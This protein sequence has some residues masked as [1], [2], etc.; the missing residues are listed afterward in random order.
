MHPRQWGVRRRSSTDSA[1]KHKAGDLRPDSIMRTSS[2]SS[3]SD[4]RSSHSSSDYYSA[5]HHSV[6]SRTSSDSQLCHPAPIAHALDSPVPIV[7]RNSAG[8]IQAGTLHGIVGELIAQASQ[9]VYTPSDQ[10][11]TDEFRRPLTIC[12]PTTRPVY[13]DLPHLYR[14][15]HP[16]THHAQHR[17]T[18][19]RC[20]YPTSLQPR[21]PAVQVSTCCRSQSVLH[22]DDSSSAC[23]GSSKDG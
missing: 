9:S 22:V 6:D 20:R 3:S 2:S 4:R 14:L 17:E 21:Q 23:S 16:G 8:L 11:L 7:H 13:V 1:E 5:D 18:L 10:T 12:F 15:H 19:H